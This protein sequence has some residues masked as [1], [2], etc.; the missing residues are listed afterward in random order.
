MQPSLAEHLP[1]L[2]PCGPGLWLA[3]EDEPP[4]RGCEVCHCLIRLGGVLIET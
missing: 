3:E 4:T 1:L 2:E